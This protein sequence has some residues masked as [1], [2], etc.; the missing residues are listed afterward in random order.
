[1]SAQRAPQRRS[2]MD[3]MLVDVPE[4][5]HGTCS[6]RR[7]TVERDSIENLRQS[8][9]GRGCQ[10]GTYTGLYR[11]NG[12]WMSDT[13]AE[14]RDHINAALRISGGLHGGTPAERVLI[15]GLGLGCI[16]RVALLT[17]GVQHVD[18]V[19]LD[20][21]VLALVGPHYQAM[22]EANGTDLVLHHADLFDQRWA[23]GTHWNVAWFD[24]WQHLCTDDL[25]DHARLARSYARRTDWYACWGH[26][27][28]LRHR[29][30][31]RRQAWW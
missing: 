30:N 11:G 14:R 5:E 19:E 26:D 13:T 18:V 23:P 29:R 17:P 27:L 21:D 12:L 25:D 4:G 10:P 20:A 15:G 9:H 7:F 8:L 22:A 24:I 28:L 2:L 3:D 31:E 6:V 1:M 16:L